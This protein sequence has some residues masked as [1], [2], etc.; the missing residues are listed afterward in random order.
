MLK[1]H[2]ASLC[3]QTWYMLFLRTSQSSYSESNLS[4]KLFHNLPSISSCDI[5]LSGYPDAVDIC[6]CYVSAYT[7]FMLLLR[8]DL[9]SLSLTFFNSFLCFL[10]SVSVD[11]F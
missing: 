9:F 2:S 8:R 5:V 6:H 11:F 3:S 1:L 4:G 7:V 10:L